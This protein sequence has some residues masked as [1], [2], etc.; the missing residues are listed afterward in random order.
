VDEPRITEIVKAPGRRL[1]YKCG[2]LDKR[3]L[4]QIERGAIQLGKA[5]FKYS[6]V[7]DNL[8]AEGQRG[9]TIDIS[10]TH[11]DIVTLSRT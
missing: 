3:K 11:Q 1:I 7:M 10:L 4:A 6:L 9:I 8:Q 2:G 5:S